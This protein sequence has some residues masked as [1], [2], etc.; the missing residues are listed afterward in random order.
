MYLE[1]ET[2]IDLN[3]L[4]HDVLLES[5]PLNINQDE[6]SRSNMNRFVSVQR[7]FERLEKLEDDNKE[8]REEVKRLDDKIDREA[9]DCICHSCGNFE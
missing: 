1:I 7:L 8:L 3:Q 2:G 9:C 6:Y 4:D 5:K